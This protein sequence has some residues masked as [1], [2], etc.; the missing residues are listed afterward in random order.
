MTWMGSSRDRG[1]C[2]WVV[3]L[4]LHGD[5]R[6]GTKCRYNHLPGLCVG[7]FTDQV[8]C[9]AQKDALLKVEEKQLWRTSFTKMIWTCTEMRKPNRQNCRP[10]R[11]R[12]RQLKHC[13][14]QTELLLL[15]LLSHL[16]HHLNFHSGLSRR[17]HVQLPILIMLPQ[18]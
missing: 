12:K 1:S 7:A 18:L 2:W 15:R 14:F 17:N 9:L 6:E 13:I 4:E 8:N 5:G 16:R 11:R 10:Q 3:K